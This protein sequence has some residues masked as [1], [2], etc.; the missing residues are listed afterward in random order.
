MPLDLGDGPVPASAFNQLICAG[1]VGAAEEHEDEEEAPS[2]SVLPASS[3]SELWRAFLQQHPQ[4]LQ[5]TE[6]LLP[7]DGLG[8]TG[9]VKLLYVK[10]QEWAVAAPGQ[11]LDAVVSDEATTCHIVAL[12]NRTTGAVALAHLDSP[13]SVR[14][15]AALE[16]AVAGETRPG[17]GEALDVYIAGGYMEPSAEALSAALLQYLACDG[18][19]TYSLQVARMSSSNTAE[20]LGVQGPVCRSLGIWLSDGAAFSGPLP[21]AA[22]GPARQL[23][24]ARMWGSRPPTDEPLTQVPYLPASS[25]VVIVPYRFLPRPWLAQLLALNDRELLQRTSTSPEL[26][27]PTFVADMRATLAMLAGSSWAEH[28]PD[29]EALRL[30]VPTVRLGKG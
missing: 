7:Q 24:G 8:R 23:R 16:A 21:E 29:G 1:L 11:G 12:R 14:G 13:M 6:A 26:E 10:Q 17:D 25:E 19:R 28:F 30:H 2:A 20:A 22:R 15:M 5:R 27:G 3:F 4:L 9:P 18:A